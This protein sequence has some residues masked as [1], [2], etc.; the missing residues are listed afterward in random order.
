MTSITVSN[1]NIP[2]GCFD[3]CTKLAQING[4]TSGTPI[5]PTS[6][7]NY[8]FRNCSLLPIST[9]IGFSNCTAIGTCAF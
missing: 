3:G 9:Y 6:I 7:G 4:L 5:Q 1:I 2:T 8:V